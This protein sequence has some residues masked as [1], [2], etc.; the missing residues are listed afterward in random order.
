MRLL[1]TA[2]DT[3]LSDAHK[4]VIHADK[5]NAG[6]HGRR[7]NARTIEEKEKWLLLQSEIYSNLKILFFL[8]ETL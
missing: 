2:I 4:I 1:I 5:M 7:F 8:E 6:E 3:K